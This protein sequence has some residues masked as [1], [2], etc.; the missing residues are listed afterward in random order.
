MTWR[1]FIVLSVVGCL[2]YAGAGYAQSRQPTEEANG[3]TDSANQQTSDQHVNKNKSL[4]KPQTP[5][6]QQPDLT[7]GLLQVTLGLFVVLLVIAGAAWLTRRF[8]HFHMS[9]GGAVR[10]VGGLHLGAKE[11]LVVV[12]VGEEQLLLGVAPGR[13]STLHILDKPL[14]EG[15]SQSPPAGNFLEKLNNA[16]KGNR[17]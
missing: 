16:L 1:I 10:I 17:A 9:A 15:Q 3:S 4:A 5:Q 14:Q 11:R 2:L 8:G 12:Q 6:I 13:V 7:T